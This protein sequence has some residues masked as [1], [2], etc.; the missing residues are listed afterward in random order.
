MAHCMPYDHSSNKH[1]IKEVVFCNFTEIKVLQPMVTSMVL[2]CNKRSV[3]AL[4]PIY[5]KISFEEKVLI[6]CIL[7]SMR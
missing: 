7:S 1:E 5:I 2:S 6:F 4:H 3:Y